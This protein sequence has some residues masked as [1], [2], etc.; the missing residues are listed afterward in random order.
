M[1]NTAG[2]RA[3][4]L[5]VRNIRTPLARR[6]VSAEMRVV[7]QLRSP[8][9]GSTGGLEAC[10]HCPSEGLS[11]STRRGAVSHKYSDRESL[12]DQR[13]KRLILLKTAPGQPLSFK[14]RP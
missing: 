8:L 3:Q 11:I 12:R 6:T 1:T 5:T 4:W 7:S 9:A 2:P 10:E 13:A 14:M